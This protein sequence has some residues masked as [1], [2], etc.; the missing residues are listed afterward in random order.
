IARAYLTPEATMAQRI[1]RAKRRI[2]E[3]GIP[4]AMPT[5]KDRS[6]RLSA[7][8]HVLYLIFNEGYASSFGPNFQ[9]NDLASEA[10]R[11]ARAVHRSLPDHAEAAGLLAL[12]LLTHARRNARTGADGTLIPLEK[13]DR[14]LW[15]QRAIAEGTRLVTE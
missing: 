13:Q 9:R 3:S 4:F 8:L 6:E 12:M 14:S 1:S 11:L 2:K 7:V 15:D 5:Q 10:I